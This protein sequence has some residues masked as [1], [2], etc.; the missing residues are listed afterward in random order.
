MRSRSLIGIPAVFSRQINLFVGIQ[1][2]GFALETTPFRPH[3]WVMKHTPHRKVTRFYVINPVGDRRIEKRFESRENVVIRQ[4]EGGRMSPGVAFDIGRY[5]MKLE[6]ELDLDMG[7]YIQVAFPKATD[8]ARCF[9][10]VVWSRPLKSAGTFEAGVSI[11]S[12]H[13]IVSG[14][15]TYKFHQGKSTKKDRRFVRR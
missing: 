14:E 8:N 3:P 12:W 10:R 13:G 2:V 9:G 11:D 6:V 7:A 15:E 5:G 4:E 1:L